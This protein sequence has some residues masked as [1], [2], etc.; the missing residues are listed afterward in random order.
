MYIMFETIASNDPRLDPKLSFVGKFW[1]YTIGY[2]A[3]EDESGVIT[4]W[5]RGTEI[6]EDV[7]KAD[8]FCSAYEGELSVMANEDGSIASMTTP[9]SYGNPFYKK[10][11]YFLTSDDTANAIRCMQEAMRLF[12]RDHTSDEPLQTQLYALIDALDLTNLDAAQMFMATYFDFDTAYTQ[13]RPRY[14]E[15]TVNWNW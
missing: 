15:F 3:P 11:A 14:P 12:T 6:S 13:G 2:V 5:L 8:K 4:S 9:T 7:A 1:H 10:A